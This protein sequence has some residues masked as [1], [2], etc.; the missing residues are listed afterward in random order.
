MYVLEV[1]LFCSKFDTLSACSRIVDWENE[2]G[3]IY[4][5]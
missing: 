3:L 5:A 1:V 2:E 4:Y